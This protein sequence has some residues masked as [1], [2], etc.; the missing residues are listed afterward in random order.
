MPLDVKNKYVRLCPNFTS[1]NK[2]N[3]TKNWH[4]LSHV[5]LS[6]GRLLNL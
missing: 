3:G 5:Y 2:I 4:V 1:E 6:V